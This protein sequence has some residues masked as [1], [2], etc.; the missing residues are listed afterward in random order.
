MGCNT[1]RHY[2]DGKPTAVAICRHRCNFLDDALHHNNALIQSHVTYMNSLKTLGDSLHRFLILIIN[3]DQEPNAAVSNSDD[4]DSDDDVIA[5]STPDHQPPMISSAWD[6]LNFFEP[7]YD[8]NTNSTTVVNVNVNDIETEKVIVKSKNE[9]VNTSSVSEIMS[10]VKLMFDNASASGIHVLNLLDAPDHI[11]NNIIV[12]EISVLC[13]EELV[14]NARSL[15]TSLRKLCVWEKKLYDEVKAEEKLRITYSR[16]C[17]QVMILEK[18]GGDAQKLDSLRVLLGNLSTEIKISVQVIDKLSVTINKLR[19]EELWPQISKLVNGWLV[20]WKT[21]LDCHRSQSKAITKVENFDAI[22]S[23]HKLDNSHLEAAI[24]LKIELQSW[25][26]NFCNWIDAQKGYVK[27]LHGWLLKCLRY[28]PEETLDP[29][30]IGAPPVF[31][32]FHYWF[33]AM[34]KISE[35]GVTITMHE[36]IVSVNQFLE[37]HNSVDLQQRVVA[38]K[39]M[40]RKVKILEREEQ[41]VQKLMQAREKKMVLVN[42]EA[43][44]LLFVG[45]R[46]H[47]TSDSV[48][49]HTCLTQFFPSMEGLSYNFTQIYEELR[50]H[51]DELQNSC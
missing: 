36:T 5:V 50:T 4:D 17:R 6:F 24:Q 12:P 34:D 8:Y 2:S 15:S 14:V 48:S 37:R 51:I 26:L 32:I 11:C 10:Q 29:E 3:N 18:K 7:L 43:N 41:K 25:K 39:D 46:L 30:I 27:A 47:H 49:L 19:D 9:E 13:D 23:I 20:M 33:K 40:E 45:D 42:G 31:K 28:E 22:L 44:S 1:S 16:K 21:M 38:D 35:K